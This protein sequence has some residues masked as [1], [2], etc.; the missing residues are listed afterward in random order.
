MHLPCRGPL[1]PCSGEPALGGQ[2]GGC[3]TCDIS[4]TC[5]AGACS[6][7]RHSLCMEPASMS[8]WDGVD[9]V[10]VTSILQGK[11]C[12]GRSQEGV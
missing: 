5:S 11:A 8:A 1:Q 10:V 6:T 3:L 7:A 12:D 2:Y 9:G 4:C